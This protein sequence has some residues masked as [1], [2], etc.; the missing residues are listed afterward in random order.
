VQGLTVILCAAT[1]NCSIDFMAINMKNDLHPS[2]SSEQTKRINKNALR[3]AAVLIGTVSAMALALLL[4]GLAVYPNASNFLP[5]MIDS[6]GA[7]ETPKI[8]ASFDVSATTENAES[9]YVKKE[10]SSTHRAAFYAFGLFLSL[11]AVVFAAFYVAT[12]RREEEESEPDI[13]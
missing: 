2:L 11:L 13:R 4:I 12:F 7:T 1:H 10:A 6:I 9:T 5:R 3:R 8:S